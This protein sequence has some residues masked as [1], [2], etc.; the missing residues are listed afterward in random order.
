[1]NNLKNK[2]Y[3]SLLILIILLSI[4]LFTVYFI[5]NKVRMY[6]TD[7]LTDYNKLAELENERNI[8]NS[9][10]KIL[11]KGSNES[12]RIKK[13][14][15][16]NDRKEVLDFINKLEDY[17]KK[18]GLIE[19]N[20]SPIVSLSP[21]ENALIQKY[22]ATDLIINIRVSG[23]KNRIDDFINI[24]NNL[25][26]ISYVERIDMKFDDINKINTAN[27]ILVIYQKNEIK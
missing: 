21:R 18:V 27:I 8:F 24:L 22:N 13:H 10:N 15:L 6:K 3:I 9:Y 20:N 5:N 16:S 19:N 12:I 26:I 1:M 17:T 2:K 23:D 11:I 7:V 25:P 14:I 4:F